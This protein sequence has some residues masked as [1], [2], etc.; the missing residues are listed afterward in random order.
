MLKVDVNQ[1][2]LKMIEFIFV[3]VFIVLGVWASIGIGVTIGC[4]AVYHHYSTYE[5]AI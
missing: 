5:A 2:T 4:R 1:K 3:G